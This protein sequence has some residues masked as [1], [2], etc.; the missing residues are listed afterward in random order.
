MQERINSTALFEVKA[1]HTNEF[2]VELGAGY[3]A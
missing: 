3:F 1:K 2:T